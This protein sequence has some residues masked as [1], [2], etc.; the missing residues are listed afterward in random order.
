MYDEIE[1]TKRVRLQLL[2]V[3]GI[4]LLITLAV[5][6]VR[7]GAAAYGTISSGT[8]ELATGI[9]RGVPTWQA[10]ARN[11]A[12]DFSTRA[13]TLQ[14]QAE[15]KATEIVE[16]IQVAATQIIEKVA[17][18]QAEMQKQQTPIFEQNRSSNEV[19]KPK[20][21]VDKPT[22]E[23]EPVKA[24]PVPAP[25]DSGN[26]AVVTAHRLNLRSGP[27][28]EYE[29]LGKLNQGT[30]VR[31]LGRNREAKWL[32]VEVQNS[33]EV[34]WV[35]G[36]YLRVNTQVSSL[37]I[38]EMQSVRTER[39]FDASYKGCIGGTP[40]GVGVVKGQVFDRNGKIIQGA[41]ITIKIDGVIWDS[42]ANPGTTN[43]DGW[44][45][46]YLTLGQ[47]I[48]FV[49]ISVP[50][51]VARLTEAAQDLKVYSRSGCF[52]HVNFVEQ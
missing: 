22:K 25:R 52:E 41:K 31:L 16:S 5:G 51:S 48:G 43:V 21:V 32:K 38:I 19:S 13:A 46:W 47:R 1:E 26:L 29:V 35:H 6:V 40:K 20:E 34:G 42:P 8:R 18:V 9:F 49:S 36:K 45:E 50:G 39:I 15:S 7:C 14:I 4:I 12:I 33:G 27:G 23:T 44:Y 3:V 30:I 10:K 28:T 2:I 17:T 11:E 24:S 37:P